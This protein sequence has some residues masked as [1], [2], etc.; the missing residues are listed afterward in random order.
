[1]ADPTSHPPTRR[2]LRNGAW[3]EL[4]EVRP[5]DKAA[6]ADG[7]AR[8]SP[9][10]RYRRFFSSLDRL[11]A[12]D[13][14]YLTEVDHRD[15]EAVIAVDLDGAPVGVARYVRGLEPDTAEVAVV[16]VDDW[17]GL[18]AGTAILERLAERATENG[19]ERFVALVL[20]ENA[21][22]IELFRSIAADSVEPRRT[23]DGYLELVLEVPAGDV[24]GTPLGRVL[25]SAASGRVAIHPWRLIKQRLQ[26][27]QSRP[28]R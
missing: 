18:G 6:L 24:A 17:Q 9:E 14:A 10:S 2:Q 4:R 8:L 1:M 3:I 22:A 21:E 15:H 7:F 26:E 20:E 12:T 16:V 25:H 19:I 27:V 11:S 5:D 13:L 28:D 23:P